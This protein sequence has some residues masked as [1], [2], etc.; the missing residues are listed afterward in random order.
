M[1][2][3]TYAAVVKKSAPSTA[4]DGAAPVPSLLALSKSKTAADTRRAT[5]AAIAK[6]SAPSTGTGNGTGPGTGAAMLSPALPA[7][8]KAATDTPKRRATYAAVVK[9]ASGAAAPVLLSLA[10]SKCATDAAVVKGAAP[11]NTGTG[12]GTSTTTAP[13]EWASLA[14]L[15]PDLN[16][17][18]YWPSSWYW[19]SPWKVAV[20]PAV[21]VL[22]RIVSPYI[23]VVV[24]RIAPDHD[25]IVSKLRELR[26]GGDVA[27]FHAAWEE[28]G[29]TPDGRAVI[30]VCGA[31][32]AGGALLG[33]VDVTEAA[34]AALVEPHWAHHFESE[35]FVPVLEAAARY[36]GAQQTAAATAAPPECGMP[37]L[38]SLLQ[39]RKKLSEQMWAPDGDGNPPS[40]L[41]MDLPVEWYMAVAP[42]VVVVGRIMARYLP[43]VDSYLDVL[44]REAET[45]TGVGRPASAIVGECRTRGWTRGSHRSWPRGGSWAARRTAAGREQG[46]P[47]T[48]SVGIVRVHCCCC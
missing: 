9:S 5:Y 18:G 39:M 48:S 22:G 34:E 20:A 23:D 31:A 3:A 10:S 17:N 8:S 32:A 27:R 14:S 30:A 41:P 40:P 11:P 35:A 47:T 43:D 29:S 6:K 25:A 37:S 24:T 33:R 7:I 21:T 1:P 2:R 16:S 46:V 44:L 36:Y 13:P 4:T 28:L 45:G 26:R 12:T 42:A 19:Y 15:T 38:D